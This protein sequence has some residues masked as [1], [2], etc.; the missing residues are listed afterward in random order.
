[1]EN[2]STMQPNKAKRRFQWNASF[3]ARIGIF[4]SITTILYVMPYLQFNIPIFP[5]FLDFH[6]DEVPIF[7]AGFAYGPFAAMMVNIIKFV[8]K[9]PMSE[10]GMIGELGDL[11]Y[12][13]AFVIPAAL[14]YAKNRTRKGALIGF[15]IGFVCQLIVSSTANYFFILDLYGISGH[16][17]KLG[18]VLSAFLPFNAVKNLL[19]ILITYPIYKRVHKI[20]E[21]I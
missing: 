19:V 18:M 7:I 3:I 6:F 20:V 8:I 17:I 11:I 4:G 16:E 2:Q 10:T 9:L 12:T 1:M 15:A 14:Y 21:L 13:T 5:S